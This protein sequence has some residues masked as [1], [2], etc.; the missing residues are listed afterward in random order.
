MYTGTGT[1]RFR[2]DLLISISIDSINPVGFTFTLLIQHPIRA[3]EF[4]RDSFPCRL[5]PDT[6]EWTGI[7]DIGFT[8]TVR[9]DTSRKI[10]GLTI[11]VP[12]FDYN[13]I[14]GGTVH[15]NGD[16]TVDT[17]CARLGR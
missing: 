4:K 2:T 16:I 12:E 13:G 10:I 3:I 7:N 11:Y 1:N 17:N 5:N 14:T 6:L 15:D 9:L 8:G